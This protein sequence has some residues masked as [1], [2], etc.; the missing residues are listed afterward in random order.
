[1]LAALAVKHAMDARG[2]AHLVLPDEVQVQASQASAAHPDG[3]LS[4]RRVRPDEA[5][6]ARA[7]QLI[8]DRQRPV[9]IVGHGARAA[10]AEV[11]QLA[12]RLG[13]PVLTTFKAKGLVPDT[14]PLGA[15]VLGRSGTSVASWPIER[16]R[17]AHCGRC[18]L[19]QP[20]GH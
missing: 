20:H 18:L 8:R 15:G 12:E 16:R 1:L 7:A 3:R 11:R 17:S 9:L 14:H 13:A 10:E 6:L 5:A 19:R 2:V 4:D